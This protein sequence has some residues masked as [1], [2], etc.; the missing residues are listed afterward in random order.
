MMLRQA[1]TS[2]GCGSY[3]A[4]TLY[5]T[6]FLVVIAYERRNKKSATGEHEKKAP[7]SPRLKHFLRGIIV[8]VCF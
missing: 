6:S 8:K 4:Q 1:P 2:K 5:F 7:E 3:G